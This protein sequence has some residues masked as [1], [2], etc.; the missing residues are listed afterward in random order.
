M[1]IFDNKG[2]KDNNMVILQ[3][4]TLD[5]IPTHKAYIAYGK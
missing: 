4:N 3:I 5:N 1:K 2:Y